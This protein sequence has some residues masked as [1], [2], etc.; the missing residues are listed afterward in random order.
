[1]EKQKN[2]M[3]MVNSKEYHD[4]G[5]LSFE[6]EYLNGERNGLAK[7]FYYNGKLKFDGEYL[8]GKRNGK[9][10]SDF[11]DDFGDLFG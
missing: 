7:E 5:K 6:G 11:S 4:N 10:Y 1:M 2:I 9:E 3:I 8:N